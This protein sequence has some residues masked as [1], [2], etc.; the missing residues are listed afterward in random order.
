MKC[1]VGGGLGGKYL[2]YQW[3]QTKLPNSECGT[4]AVLRLSITATVVLV[5]GKNGTR[6]LPRSNHPIV[7]AVTL[8]NTTLRSPPDTYSGFGRLF[9]LGQSGIESE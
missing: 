2:C 7:I 1:V 5:D 9:G 3:K 4:V 8:K 6:T